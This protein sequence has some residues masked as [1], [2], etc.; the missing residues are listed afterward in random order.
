MK[1]ALCANT[2]VFSSTEPLGGEEEWPTEG[3]LQAR[4]NNSEA[5]K[6]LPSTLDHLD[7]DKHSEL[8]SLIN[9]YPT[10]FSYTPSQTHLIEHDIDI[11]EAQPIRQRFYRVSPDKRAQLDNDVEYMLKN[12]IAE[13][14]NSSWASPCVLDKND[15]KKLIP[16]YGLAQ[17]TES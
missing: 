7:E 8:I 6:A 11:S 12:K 15:K 13:P 16:P 5:L 17:T 4:L 3:V 14:S 2:G 9:A 10:L 1:A